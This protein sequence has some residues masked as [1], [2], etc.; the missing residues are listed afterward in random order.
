MAH[1]DGSSH[2]RNKSILLQRYRAGG[3]PWFVIIDK[4]GRVI[5]NGFHINVASVIKFINRELKKGN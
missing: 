5:F 3:T 2:K 1:D 4:K